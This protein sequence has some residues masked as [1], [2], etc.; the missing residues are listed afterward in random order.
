VSSLAAIAQPE[1]ATEQ[2]KGFFDI[3][4]RSVKGSGQVFPENF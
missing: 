1:G 4:S 2:K 3:V